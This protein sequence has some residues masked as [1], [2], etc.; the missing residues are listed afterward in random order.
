MF[1]LLHHQLSLTCIYLV[2]CMLSKNKPMFPVKLSSPWC[3]LLGRFCGQHPPVPALPLCPGSS[4]ERRRRDH[5]DIASTHRPLLDTPAARLSRCVTCQKMEKQTN[6]KHW[7]WCNTHLLTVKEAWTLC[8][9]VPVKEAWSVSKSRRHAFVFG[10]SNKGAWPLLYRFQ[11]TRRGHCVCQYK[12]SLHTHTCRKEVC[13]IVCIC[14]CVWYRP[15]PFTGLGTVNVTKLPK[16]ETISSRWI[17]VAIHC[18]HGTTG[19]HLKHLTN[20]NIHLKIGD[21][22]PELWSCEVKRII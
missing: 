7:T 14:V 12:L 13:I 22:T 5:S 3:R 4:S 2:N 17:H 16:A 21:G 20:L 18:H 1:H 11:W 8:Q 19:Q 10:S 15:G 6:V 9:S